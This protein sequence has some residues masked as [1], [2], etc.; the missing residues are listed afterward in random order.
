M[1]LY[2]KEVRMVPLEKS[3]PIE[4]HCDVCGKV[5]DAR[6][7]FLVSTHHSDWGND[8]FESLEYYDICSDKC[9]TEFAGKYVSEAYRGINTKTIEIEHK[10]SIREIDEDRDK[11]AFEDHATEKE[12]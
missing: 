7:W 1:L 11:I 3:E 2:K 8:S 4:M 9:V 10:R 6:T 12:D 5:I